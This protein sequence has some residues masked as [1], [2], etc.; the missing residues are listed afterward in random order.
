MSCKASKHFDNFRAL[1]NSIKKALGDFG[2]EKSL[3][4]S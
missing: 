1:V 3:V 4:L 2:K